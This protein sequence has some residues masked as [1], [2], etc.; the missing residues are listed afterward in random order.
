MPNWIENVVKITGEKEDLKNLIEK[1]K[2]KETSFS[3][4]SFC[5]NLQAKPYHINWNI[6]NWGTKWDA[7]DVS[8]T[9]ET[10]EIIFE[11]NTANS[12]PFEALNKLSTLFPNT[13]I[14]CNYIDIEGGDREDSFYIFK[15]G[16]LVEENYLKGEE[17]L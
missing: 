7:Q 5:P 4:E 11:F 12:T 10:N 8:E 6:E 2:G 15:N 13:T 3:F 17:E 16:V 1:V 14:T 9:F